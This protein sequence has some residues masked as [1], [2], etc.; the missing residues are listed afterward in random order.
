MLRTLSLHRLTPS[1]VACPPHPAVQ[2][3][4]YRLLDVF[5]RL[6]YNTKVDQT[7]L[8]L[9]RNNVVGILQPLNP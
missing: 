1:S 3:R 6:D 7:V 5:R 8:V 4:M 9:L 2:L